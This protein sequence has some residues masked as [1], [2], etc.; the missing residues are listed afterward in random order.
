MQPTKN[1]L[2]LWLVTCPDGFSAEYEDIEEMFR[3]GLSRLILDKKSRSGAPRASDDEYERWLMSLDMEYRDRIWVRG[4]PDLAERLE[5]RGC[6]AD[7]PSLTGDVPECWKRVNCVALCNSLEEY[8]MLPEWVSGAVFGPFFQPL[9]ALDV[10]KTL[11]LDYLKD[12]QEPARVP[13]IAWGGVEPETIPEIKKMP[14]S[15]VAVLG[16]IWNYADPIN[17]FIK[18]QRAL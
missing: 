11:P 17:A 7:A 6:V 10:V 12:V 4:T 5:V 16:G 2:R 15:G 13:I 18:M 9:S 8:C 1:K 3:R 14:V